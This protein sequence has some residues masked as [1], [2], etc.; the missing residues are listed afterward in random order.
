VRR[1]QGQAPSKVA[2]LCLARPCPFPLS[3]FGPIL[4]PTATPSLVALLQAK[5]S[6]VTQSHTESHSPFLGGKG[7]GGSAGPG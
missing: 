2:L 1:A 4:P 3:P 6:R 5:D 7:A